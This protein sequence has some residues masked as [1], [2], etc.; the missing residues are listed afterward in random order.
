M[1]F[2]QI[3]IEAIVPGRHG[4]MGSENHFP[5]NAR[6]GGV[7]SNAL[8]GHAHVDGFQHRESAVPFVQ[9]KNAGRDAHGSKG[10]RSA[11]AKHQLLTDAGS[12]VSA[13]KAGSQFAVV[14]SVTFDVG[15][16]EEQ[17]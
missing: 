6:H 7:E 14:R 4:S 2:D 11:N 3:C 12:S 13:V 10:A 9:V 1:L 16:E 5:G 8:V 17:V 15:V